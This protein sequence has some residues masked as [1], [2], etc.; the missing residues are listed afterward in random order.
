MSNYRIILR[1]TQPGRSVDEVADA[2]AR[3]SKKSPDKL[4]ELLGSGKHMVA[5]RTDVAQQAAH[6][7]LLLEKLGCD[8]FIEAE[9]TKP[10]EQHHTTSVLVTDTVDARAVEAVP[11][12][13]V[14]YVQHSRFGEMVEHLGRKF[15]S[16]MAAGVIIL[17]AVFY[18]RW[19]GIV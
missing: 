12:R 13:G 4:R 19:Q 18:M 8:C 14:T 9:M 3:Y 6:Y 11:R 1:G 2:L 7:K 16:G 10:T 15:W 5:K 17:L